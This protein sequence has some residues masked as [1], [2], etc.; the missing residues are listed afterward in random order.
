MAK[1]K[2]FK[3]VLITVAVALTALIGMF[4]TDAY[5]AGHLMKPIFAKPVT[6]TTG[7]GE[8]HDVYKGIGY[9]VEAE[10]FISENSD[11]RLI[12]V[13]MYVGDKTVS[14]SIT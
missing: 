2:I 6:V 9:T 1:R 7:Y 12:A 11:K 3:A 4:A 10:T 14:A 8:G 5:C 13:T